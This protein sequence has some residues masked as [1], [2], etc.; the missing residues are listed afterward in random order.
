MKVMKKHVL[1]VALLLLT[2]LTGCNNTLKDQISID[3]YEFYSLKEI[4]RVIEV[5]EEVHYN[6]ISQLIQNKQKCR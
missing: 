2:S 5:P 1:I 6:S 4:N 3:D